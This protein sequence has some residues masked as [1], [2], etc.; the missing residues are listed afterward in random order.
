[1]R[2]YTNISSVHLT[3]YNSLC[4]VKHNRCYQIRTKI[5]AVLVLLS[6]DFWT[7]YLTQPIS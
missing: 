6:L 5:D 1:M 7:T 3:T 2:F 4:D